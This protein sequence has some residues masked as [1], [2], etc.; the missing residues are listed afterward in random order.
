MIAG[1]SV[2][3]FSAFS[4][5]MLISQNNNP[6]SDT[7][8]LQTDMQAPKCCYD[9]NSQYNRSLLQYNMYL[10]Q[11]SFSQVVQCGVINNTK[12]REREK[13]SVRG[14]GY[15]SLCFLFYN[16]TY[17]VSSR[18]VVNPGGRLMRATEWSCVGLGASLH[19]DR[20]T[21]REKQRHREQA[22]Y[23]RPQTRDHHHSHMPKKNLACHYL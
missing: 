23:K 13:E 19:A 7:G 16:K 6:L 2:Y 17:R 18:K 1:S 9:S 15:F 22:L 4:L 5:N 21:G 3:I 14:V 12:E 10:L 11:T 20:N 8:G